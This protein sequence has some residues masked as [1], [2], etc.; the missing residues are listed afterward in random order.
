MGM[1]MRSV[2]GGRF[3]QSYANF[4]E[5]VRLIL[6]YKAIEPGALPQNLAEAMCS[7]LYKIAYSD[8]IRCQII[9]I[10]CAT[11]V[12]DKQLHKSII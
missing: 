7:F 3:T 2:V 9:Q 11:E 5:P 10:R 12:V 1:V 8:P 6:P 4:N